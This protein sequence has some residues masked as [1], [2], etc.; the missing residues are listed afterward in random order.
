MLT[1][2]SN[3]GFSYGLNEENSRIVSF[4]NVIKIDGMQ[5]LKTDIRLEKIISYQ[6][7]KKPKTDTVVVFTH[8]S[9][10]KLVSK[11]LNLLCEQL[12]Q[13]DVKFI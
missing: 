1:A 7:I 9:K 13:T 6:L 12:Y 5:Y 8:E 4:G 2:D 3:T 11:R 10:Y